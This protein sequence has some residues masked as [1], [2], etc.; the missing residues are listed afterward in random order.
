MP[1]NLKLRGIKIGYIVKPI[2]RALILA[3]IAWLREFSHPDKVPRRS[4]QR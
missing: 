4:I 3:R 1:Q 2:S